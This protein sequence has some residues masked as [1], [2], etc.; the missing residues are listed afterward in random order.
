M[1]LQV[2]RMPRLGQELS[3]MLDGEEITATVFSLDLDGNAEL[4]VAGEED[5]DE[6]DEVIEASIVEGGDEDD[7]VEE[8][9]VEDGEDDLEE[10]SEEAAPYKPRRRVKGKRKLS[11]AEMLKRKQNNRKNRV[12][13]RA[14]DRRYAAKN[15]VKIARNAKKRLAMHITLKPRVKGYSYN[16]S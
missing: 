15:K 16:Y 2:N 13:N 10:G 5:D 6:E 11:P 1:K 4:I 14:Y 3:F 7:D 8:A 9:D 12:K